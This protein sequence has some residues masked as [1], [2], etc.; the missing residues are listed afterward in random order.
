MEMKFIKNNKDEL[1]LD[2]D[3]IGNE[4]EDNN[5]ELELITNRMKE[6]TEIYNTVS[7]EEKI[8]LQEE[9]LLLKDRMDTLI[10]LIM[11]SVNETIKES[12]EFFNDEDDE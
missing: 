4:F 7:D 9:T 12:D 6:I 11:A 5:K 10:P 2:F 3:R 1:V 8:K